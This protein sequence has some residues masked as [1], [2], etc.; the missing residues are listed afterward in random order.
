MIVTVALPV[1][2]LKFDGSAERELRPKVRSSL[3]ATW[4]LI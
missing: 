3:D 4:T 2:Y 1:A